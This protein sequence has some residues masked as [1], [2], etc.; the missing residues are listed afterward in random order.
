MRKFL[1]IL[2]A[3]FAMVAFASGVVAQEKKAEQPA[4]AAEKA[5]AVKASRSAP[6]PAAGSGNQ[7]ILARYQAVATDVSP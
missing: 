1:I 3:L 7:C 4:P 2:V 6:A 5:K